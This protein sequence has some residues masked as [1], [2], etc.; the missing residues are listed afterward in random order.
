[1]TLGAMALGA[2]VYQTGQE[3]DMAE[4]PRLWLQIIATKG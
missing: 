1:L 2:T 4:V 3:L